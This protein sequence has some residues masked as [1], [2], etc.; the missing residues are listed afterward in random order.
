MIVAQIVLTVQLIH[1]TVPMRKSYR[2]L[3]TG[4]P[5]P[6]IESTRLRQRWVSLWRMRRILELA[7]PS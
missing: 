1:P 6:E 4:L 2:T 5:T 3:R 7:M